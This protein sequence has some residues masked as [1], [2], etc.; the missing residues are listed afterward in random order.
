MDPGRKRSSQ[1]RKN[2]LNPLDGLDDVRARLSL[3]IKQH[4]W[5]IAL[6]RRRDPRGQPVV[7]HA[8]RNVR[9]ILQ[10]NWAPVSICENDR[11][12]IL[13]LEDL[14]IRT[15]SEGL[16]V[17]I[18]A[19]LGGIN[20]GLRNRGTGV[21]QA[22]PLRSQ[23]RRVDLHTHRRLLIAFDRDK[24]DSTYL[25]ELL[26]EDR[27]GEIINLLEGKVIRSDRERED[28]SIRR[29][30]LVKSWRIRHV[31]RKQS[32]RRVDGRLHV[33]AGFVNLSPQNELQG[34]HRRAK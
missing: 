34:D 32:A 25:A 6:S 30:D 7:F 10:P 5:L 12:E 2:L 13:R 3:N 14:I 17:A 15:E 19:P 16:L 9:H 4:R 28:W 31:R 18:E 21:F 33:L 23:R 11:L 27:V 24:P 8:V 29:I 20:V 26:R 22:Q 1:A